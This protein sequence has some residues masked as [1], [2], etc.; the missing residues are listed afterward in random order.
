MGVLNSNLLVILLDQWLENKKYKRKVPHFSLDRCAHIKKDTLHGPL[1]RVNQINKRT[2]DETDKIG[3][4]PFSMKKVRTDYGRDNRIFS[5]KN[6]KYTH[7]HEYHK[8]NVKTN[9]QGYERM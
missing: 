3:F 8:R 5:W 4:S 7:I 2:L 6:T 9:I 1:I